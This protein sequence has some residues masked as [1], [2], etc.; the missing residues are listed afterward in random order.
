MLPNMAELLKRRDEI[1]DV[2]DCSPK[3]AALKH[4]LDKREEEHVP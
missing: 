2:D 1:V 4:C 3:K